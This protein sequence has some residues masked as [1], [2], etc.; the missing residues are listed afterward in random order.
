MQ[1]F[2]G[3]NLYDLSF[4][5]SPTPNPRVHPSDQHWFGNWGK[6][7]FITVIEN[8]SEQFIILPIPA[9]TSINIL[10]MIYEVYIFH[11][12]ASVMR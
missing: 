4:M 12:S 11:P 8:C 1:L 3:L 9:V 2:L 7:L 10:V 5:H 6:S